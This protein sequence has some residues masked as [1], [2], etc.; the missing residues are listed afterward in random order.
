MLSRARSQS[1]FSLTELLIGSV[2]GLTV[3]SGGVYA[4]I[5]I[6]ESSHRHLDKLRLEHELRSIIA[7]MKRDL[8][9]A[10]YWNWYPKSTRSPA[11]N[12]F[13]AP[14]LRPTTGRASEGEPAE[15]CIAFSYDLDQDGLVSDDSMEFF[16]YRLRDGAIEM[17]SSGNTPSC[18]EGIW[19][20]VTTSIVN[21]TTLHFNIEQYESSL[22]SPDSPCNSGETCRTNILVTIEIDAELTEDP[23]VRHH[24]VEKTWLNN[25]LISA[26]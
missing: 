17:R 12:P 24:I 19:Q 5:S 23:E 9:R 25:A 8:R 14:A 10:G 11:D 18:Q 1:G 4:Y 20:D 7:V 26:S 6:N 13:M 3:I 2:L 22:S 15:S 16:A 21:V